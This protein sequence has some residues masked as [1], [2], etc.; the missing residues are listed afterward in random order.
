[1]LLGTSFATVEDDAHPTDARNRSEA[2]A[3]CV[4]CGRL[5]PFLCFAFDRGSQAE[6]F[7]L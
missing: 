2:Q 4:R 6:S 3:R 7:A 1:L 5:A